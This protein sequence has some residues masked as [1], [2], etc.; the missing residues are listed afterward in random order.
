MTPH[1]D[2]ALL[3]DYLHG[4][5][6]PAE[7]ARLHAHLAACDD[8]RARYDEEAA[9]GDLLR[10][11]AGGELAFPATIKAG[12]WAAI[13]AQEPTL[14]DRLRALLRPVVAV[15]LAAVAAVGLYL[16]VPL[17][18]PG[19]GG[20]A[21]AAAY[22]FDEHQAEGQ[23]NPLADRQANLLEPA[24]RGAS[25]AG[26]PLVDAAGAATLDTPDLADGS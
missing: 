13:R 12:V 23:E 1:A 19:A 5:L 20:P 4:E 18:R 7:D 21:V 10:A 24:D 8:C 16:G 17:V 2:D 6:A 11:E 15:P 9:L 3:I 26:A 25:V 14:G 22:Y